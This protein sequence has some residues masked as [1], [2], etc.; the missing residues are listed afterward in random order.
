[1]KALPVVAGALVLGF[2]LVLFLSTFRQTRTHVYRGSRGEAD[3]ALEVPRDWKVLEARTRDPRVKF[4][5]GRLPSGHEAQLKIWAD[6]L[7]PG[8]WSPGTDPEWRRTFRSAEA[9]PISPGPA[10][11]WS[12]SSAIERAGIGF[13]AAA[14]FPKDLPATD[15]ALLERC[16]R[17]LRRIGP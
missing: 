6:P 12:M 8:G 9:G 5:Q 4:L 1:V 10:V 17:S 3:F 13:R 14:V 11:P 15:Y 16:L 2:T 7:P